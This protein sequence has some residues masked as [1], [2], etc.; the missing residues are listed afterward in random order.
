MNPVVSVIILTFNSQDFIARA[1]ASVRRQTFQDIETVVVDAGSTD[2]TK[3]IVT[4]FG[5]VVWLDL[6]KSDMGMARNHG[7]RH[8]RGQFLMFLDSDDFYLSHKVEAQV[9]ALRARPDLG[10]LF[11]LAYIYRTGQ[12]QRLGVKSA[13]QKRLDCIDLLRGN[14][15]TLATICIRR[16]TWDSGLAFGEGE[17]G[18]YAEDWRFQLDLFKKH[19]PFDVLNVPAMVVEIRPDSSTSWEIQPKMK[20]FALTAVQETLATAAETN[21][22][23]VDASAILD[24][25]RYKL[26]VS[27][28]LLG[29]TAEA[30]K[31]RRDIG[32]PVKAAVVGVLLGLASVLPAAWLRAVLERT[33][34][35][36]QNRSFTWITTPVDIDRQISDITLNRIRSI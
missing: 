20:S 16:S 22:R 23:F 31:V 8:S 26:A 2:G 6:P 1:L 30:R 36:R 9:S 10:A 35:W 7:V 12:T 34:T 13:T 11:A 17:F 19:V 33:W 3:K 14:C 24:S 28:I 15:Y 5:G 4:D 29:R 27:L 32:T 18:L 21:T 25:Y